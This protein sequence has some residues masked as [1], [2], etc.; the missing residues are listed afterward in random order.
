M[1][2]AMLVLG[3]L[4]QRFELV[5]YLNY[6]LKV[7]EGLDDQARRLVDQDQTAARSNHRNRADRDH[8]RADRRANR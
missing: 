5:D 3:M 1:Q 4:L 8:H 7:K 2:E 6:Q